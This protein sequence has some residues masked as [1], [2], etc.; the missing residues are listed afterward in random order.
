MKSNVRFRH[1]NHQTNF[2]LQYLSLL[3]FRYWS[4]NNLTNKRAVS[5]D[6]WCGTGLAQIPQSHIWDC[7]GWSQSQGW[8]RSS[9]EGCQF[10]HSNPWKASGSLTSEFYNWYSALFLWWLPITKMHL[11]LS[12]SWFSMFDPWSQDLV[13][14]NTVQFCDL[15]KDLCLISA[16]LHPQL[17]CAISVRGCC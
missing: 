15:W 7:N 4:D 17:G 13:S 3:A 14:R 1:K 16:Y 11:C 2:L 8:S 9:T 6:L 5:S 10:T 12:G